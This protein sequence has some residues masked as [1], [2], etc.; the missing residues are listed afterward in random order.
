M[1]AS[2]SGTTSLYSYLKRHTLFYPR[3]KRYVDAVGR[4]QVLILLTEDLKDARRP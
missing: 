2:K 1:G 3:V 4:E